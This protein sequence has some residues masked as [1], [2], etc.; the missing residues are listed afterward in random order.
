M[1]SA[2][3]SEHRYLE[4]ERSGSVASPFTIRGSGRRLAA[5]PGRLSNAP[6][7]GA[8]GEAAL[9]LLGG[10]GRSIHQTEDLIEWL[11]FIGIAQREPALAVMRAALPVATPVQAL[12]RILVH[13]KVRRH[14]PFPSALIGRHRDLT[15]GTAR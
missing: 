13:A 9:L 15:C 5:M 3:E 14:V 4:P 2:G 7:A 6:A 11:T 1:G 8:A 10:F 12:T